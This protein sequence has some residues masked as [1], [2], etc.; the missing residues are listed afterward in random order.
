MT[1]WAEGKLNILNT[2]N[3]Y[4]E[5]L[6]KMPIHMVLLCIIILIF[7]YN[8]WQSNIDIYKTKVSL[9]YIHML[10]WGKNIHSNEELTDFWEGTWAIFYIKQKDGNDSYIKILQTIFETCI[11]YKWRNCAF[12]LQAFQSSVSNEE[13]HPYFWCH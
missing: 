9:F 2:I 7:Q 1:Y 12:S 13:M 3:S 8:T 6:K 4:L 11:L 5:T 10:C